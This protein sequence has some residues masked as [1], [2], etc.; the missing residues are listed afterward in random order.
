MLVQIC[1]SPAS[2]Q[3]TVQQIESTPAAWFRISALRGPHEKALRP[4]YEPVSG[5]GQHRLVRQ[6]TCP[7]RGT[8]TATGT[9]HNTAMA[10]RWLLENVRILARWSGS[11][12]TF[13]PFCLQLK[14]PSQDRHRRARPLRPGGRVEDVRFSCLNALC[15]PHKPAL[16]EGDVHLQKHG[17]AVAASRATGR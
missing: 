4:R 17:N 13:T 15:A 14:P 3:A 7:P 16:Y 12:V 11:G 6:T 10:C 2:F 8:Q 9:F 5:E 1:D